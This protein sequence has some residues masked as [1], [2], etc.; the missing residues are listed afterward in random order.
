MEGVGALL[1][2]SFTPP[3]AQASPAP[4]S[5]TRKPMDRRALFCGAMSSRM[6]SN[7]VVRSNLGPMAFLVPGSAYM[8][9]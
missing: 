7:R 9:I 5:S 6:A 1:G 8:I 2:L 3:T 4:P